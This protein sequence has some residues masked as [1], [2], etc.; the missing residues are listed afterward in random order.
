MLQLAKRLL[1]EEEGQGMVEYGLILALVSVVV[2]A[3]LA[4]IGTQLNVHFKD[5]LTRLGGTPPA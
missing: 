3:V 5:I 1:V 2:V 4:L